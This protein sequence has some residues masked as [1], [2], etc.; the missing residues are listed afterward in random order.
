VIRRSLFRRYARV[1]I[2]IARRDKLLPRVKEDLRSFKELLN[3]HPELENFFADNKVDPLRKQKLLEELLLVADY[4]EVTKR[5]LRLIGARRRLPYFGE[6]WEAFER[7]V[8]IL[9]GV[10]VAEVASPLPLSAGQT[11]KIARQVSKFLAKKVEIKSSVDPS[12]IGGIVIKI[13]DTVYDGSLKKQLQLLKESIVQ[14]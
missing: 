1:L 3:S 2:D 11:K 10:V 9:E 8:N 12:L 6:I 14:G 4:E 5:F 13:G 7:E